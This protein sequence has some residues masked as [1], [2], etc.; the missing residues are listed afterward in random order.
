MLNEMLFFY[1]TEEL[2]AKLNITKPTLQSIFNGTSSTKVNFKLE[3][4][5]NSHVQ[6][7]METVQM[8][9]LRE[10]VSN[11]KTLLVDTPDGAQLISTF[12]DKKARNLVQIRTASHQLIC[13]EDHLVETDFGWVYAKD[14]FGQSVLTTSGFEP[15][16]KVQCLPAEVVYDFEVQ[17][18]NHRYWGGSGISSH[19]S[20]KSFELCN[21]LKNAQEE[22]AFILALDSESALDRGYMSKIGMKLDEDN[23]QYAGVSTFN[24]VVSIISDFIKAYVAAYGYD[25]FN[26]PKVIIALDSID[27]LMTDTENDNFTKGDQKGDQGQ[28]AKQGKH[29]LRT[30]VSR[31]KRLPFA[32]I[33]THQVYPNNDLTNG[34]G[35][36][37]VNNAIKYSASQIFLITN[38]RLKEEGVTT[39]IRMKVEAYKSRFARLGTKVEV[40]VPYTAGMNKFSGLL[41][42]LEDNKIITGGTWKGLQLPGQEVI[43]FQ[44]RHLNDELFTKIMSHPLIKQ[45]EQEVLELMNTVVDVSEIDIDESDKTSSIG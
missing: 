31:I 9:K 20:G 32:F 11:N 35:A 5:F 22:G 12:F 14:V 17:H 7:N 26:A 37:I 2:C 3:Q 21:I 38:A 41:A 6:K 36:W 13:S 45:E 28:R 29:M 34:A 18:Q 30:I 19:N 16:A 1:S 25:N 33:V 43:K 8:S 39:G 4:A 40:E 42:L 10:L 27:M 44:E 15:V 24:H 23:F